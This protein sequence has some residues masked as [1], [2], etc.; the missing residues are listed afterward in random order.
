M[1]DPIRYHQAVGRQVE[2][3]GTLLYSLRNHEMTLHFQLF[4]HHS[5]F[6]NHSRSERPIGV[7]VKDVRY[8]NEYCFSGRRIM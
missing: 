4:S 3:F 6:L 2:H 8:K 7:F 5:A 1:D